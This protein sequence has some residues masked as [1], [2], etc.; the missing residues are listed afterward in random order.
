MA[1]IGLVESTKAVLA[2]GEFGRAVKHPGPWR[3]EDC[4]YV[5]GNDVGMGEEASHRLVLAA[6]ELLAALKA[7]V[8]LDERCGVTPQ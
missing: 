4:Q 2:A 7:L 5:D 6:P 3:Y 1:G 8:A